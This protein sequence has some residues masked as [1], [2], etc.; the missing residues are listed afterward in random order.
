MKKFFALML[1]LML[2]VTASAALADGS[3]VVYS[4]HDADPLNAG[5]AMFQAAYPDIDVQV[6]AAGTGELC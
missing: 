5:V 1:A 6:I 2:L 3:L 4:P